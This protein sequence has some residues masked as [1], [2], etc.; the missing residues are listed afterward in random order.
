M[1]NLIYLATIMLFFAQCTKDDNNPEYILSGAA[2]KGKV[3]DATVTVYEYDGSGSR[4]NELTKTITNQD[5]EFSVTINFP[6][7]VE[8][9]VTG[10]TYSDEATGTSIS[11]NSSELRT[12][13]PGSGSPAVAV[14]ALTTIASAYVD[15]HANLGLTKAIARAEEVVS[16]AFG[17]G[18]IDILNTIPADLSEVSSANASQKAL[19]YGAVQAGLSQIISMKNLDPSVLPAFIQDMADDFRDG[20]FDG[21]NGEAALEFATGITPADAANGLTKAIE[22]FLNGTNNRS[23]KAPTWIFN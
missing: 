6:G 10:G 16:N 19:Q 4:G 8:V 7:V 1:K 22:N 14:T 9:V 15:E 17:I 12:I 21:K 5:G 3:V 23:N 11:L 20:V 13:V 2:V 18:N